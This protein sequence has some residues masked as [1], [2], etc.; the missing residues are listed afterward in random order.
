MAPPKAGLKN[1]LKNG[2]KAVGQAVS[3]AQFVNVPLLRTPMSYTVWLTRLLNTPRNLK[4]AARC[5]KSD[6]DELYHQQASKQFKNQ[7]ELL[8]K[9]L[10]EVSITLMGVSSPLTHGVDHYKSQ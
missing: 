9:A 3:K 7:S 2:L 8:K 5:V 1:G 4:T 10:A 6:I